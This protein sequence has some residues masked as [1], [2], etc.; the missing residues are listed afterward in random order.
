M[1]LSARSVNTEEVVPLNEKSNVGPVVPQGF[2]KLETN[3]EPALVSEVVYP[4]AGR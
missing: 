4:I 2:G 1:L 3:V